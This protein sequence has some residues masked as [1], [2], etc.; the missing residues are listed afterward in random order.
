[1]VGLNGGGWGVFIAPTTILAV[2][3][4]GHTGHGT[5]HCPVCATSAD[6]WGLER[7]PVEVLCPL[8]APDGP[9][10][11]DLAVLTSNFCT[12]YCSVV[13]AVDRWVHT[14][15]PLAHRTVR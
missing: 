14:I 13:S 4:D 15:A 3:I 11:S 2:A 10:R 8:T 12:V 5:V 9:V 6:R 7:L 1:L